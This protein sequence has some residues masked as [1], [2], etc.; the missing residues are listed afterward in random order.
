LDIGVSLEVGS[1]NLEF[2]RRSSGVAKLFHVRLFLFTVVVA[3]AAVAMA[4][5][6]AEPQL[7]NT[8]RPLPMSIDPAFQFRKTKLF[9]MTEQDPTLAQ[10]KNATNDPM[11][12]A[13][14]KSKQKSTSA[15]QDAS[16]VFERQYRLFGAVTRLDQRQRFG[17]YY[18]FFWLAKKSAPITVRLEYRQEKLHAHVQA[19]EV[20]LGTVHG[21]QKTSFK[22]VGDD[23]FDN[24]RVLAWRCLLIDNGVIVA[25]NR[26]YLWR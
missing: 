1:W 16:I 2:P 15:V 12:Q 23:Y 22:V 21:K 4:A 7:L 5:S 3:S 8:V 10:D 24:G 6:R 11:S 17:D 19:Q 13:T 9:H 25:E 18:D 20:F 26:S 14:G